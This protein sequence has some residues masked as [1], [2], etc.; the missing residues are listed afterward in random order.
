M[1]LDSNSTFP[2]SDR[3]SRIAGMA[4]GSWPMAT[5]THSAVTAPAASI[6]AESVSAGSPVSDVIS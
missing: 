5:R 4:T 1:L 3:A 6:L 2:A